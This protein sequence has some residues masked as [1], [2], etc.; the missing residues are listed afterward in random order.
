MLVGRKD[1]P[2]P[3]DH[4]LSDLCDICVNPLNL[5]ANIDLRPNPANIGGISRKSKTKTPAQIKQ[6]QKQNIQNKTLNKDLKANVGAVYH[7]L[8]A[9]SH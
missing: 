3:F 8:F 1:V 2:K 9:M 7:A 4:N 5:C 6:K